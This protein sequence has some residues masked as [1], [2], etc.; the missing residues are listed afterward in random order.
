MKILSIDTSSQNCSIAIIEVLSSNDF[1][2]LSQKNSADERTHSQKLMPMIEEIFNECNLTLNDINLLA[3]CVGPGSF[4]GI[5]I[6]VATV[7]AFCDSKN[8]PIVGVTSLESLAYNLN[9][10]GTI[11]SIIDAK[12]E[13]VYISGFEYK[14][15][16]YY[17]KLEPFA[18]NIHNAL[19]KCSGLS[20]LS[21]N[22]YFIGNGSNV[23]KD[24]IT[25]KFSTYHIVFA[26][27]NMQSAVSLAKCAYCK[28]LNGDFGYSNSIS[29][30]YLR[31]S[32]AERIADG[33]SN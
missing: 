3:C 12:N 16:T 26:Q 20:D 19:D 10:E 13:N 8:I 5:R 28:Y 17:S 18:D 21:N 33:E 9:S 7:K 27:N 32:Q 30:I 23:F 6:G 11:F 25:D 22:I 4:T 24:Y 1:K 31:K 14:N 29:P 15:N 2:I